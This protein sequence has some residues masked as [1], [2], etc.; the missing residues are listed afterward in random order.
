MT[1]KSHDYAFVVGI[2]GGYSTGGKHEDLAEGELRAHGIA[3]LIGQGEI[4]AVADHH[5]F[6]F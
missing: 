5:V 1:L 2:E 4:V 6:V 3:E